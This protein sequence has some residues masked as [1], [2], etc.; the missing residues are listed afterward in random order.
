MLG[1]VLRAIDPSWRLSDAVIDSPI[2]DEESA[3]VP[4]VLDADA[5]AAIL[6]M[7]RKSVLDSCRTGKIPATKIGGRWVFHRD[8]FL[9]W[10]RDKNLQNLVHVK[11]FSARNSVTR[12]PLDFPT[13][14]WSK[15]SRPDDSGATKISLVE[16]DSQD[17][18]VARR[19][20]QKCQA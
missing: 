14:D 15:I 8:G 6:Q 1:N 12:L 18:G 19:R 5:I 3:K 4:K 17:A 16:S 7:P 2:R 11:A 13:H 9:E 10:L 20:R